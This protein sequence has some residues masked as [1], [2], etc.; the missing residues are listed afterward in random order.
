MCLENISKGTN[1]NP[2][3]FTVKEKVINNSKMT[4]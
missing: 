2:Y 4:Y 3:F 1:K